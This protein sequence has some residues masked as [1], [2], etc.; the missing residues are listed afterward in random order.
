MSVARFMSAR[1]YGLFKRGKTIRPIH[2]CS[3]SNMNSMETA[4]V[5]F[6][7]WSDDYES[8]CMEATRFAREIIGERLEWTPGGGYLAVF[9]VN[10]KRLQRGTGLYSG[11]PSPEFY[12]PFYNRKV[13]KLVRAEYRCQT[14]I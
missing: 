4:S 10:S 14:M 3:G 8:E 1:E 6:F 7:P 2:D 9:E 12:M 5:C 11:N 13:A